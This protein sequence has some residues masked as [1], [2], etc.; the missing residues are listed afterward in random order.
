MNLQQVWSVFLISK[1]SLNISMNLERLL[2]PNAS[3]QAGKE[4]QSVAS[5]HLVSLGGV[6]AAL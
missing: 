5:M 3:R 2:R 1:A 6:R 4:H